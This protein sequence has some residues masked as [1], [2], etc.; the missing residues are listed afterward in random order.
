MKGKIKKEQ[1][2]IVICNKCG[3][4][5]VFEDFR[6]LDDVDISTP[7][8]KCGFLLFRHSREE[9]RA[10]MLLTQTDPKAMELFNRDSFE[11]FE[12]YFEEKT[13]LLWN[14]RKSK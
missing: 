14:V 9:M 13:G 2:V 7:C 8:H 10:S 4:K 12:G 11:D 5:Y 3:E 6:M 1:D